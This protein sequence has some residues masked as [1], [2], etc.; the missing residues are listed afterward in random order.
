MAK[1]GIIGAGIFFLIIA[2]IGYLVPVTDMGWTVPG[3]DQLCSSGFGQ[4]GQAFS[5]DLQQ[6]CSTYKII[7]LGIYGIGL[8]GLILIGFCF[9]FDAIFLATFL[10]AA[11]ISRS[12]SRTPAS[13]V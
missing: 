12:S 8:L 5:G 11:A 1:G 9:L 2:I 7:T 13:R 4:L 3:V 6:V 10:K